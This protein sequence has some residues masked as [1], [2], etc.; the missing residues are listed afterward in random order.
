M[1]SLIPPIG[2]DYV[3]QVRTSPKTDS[4]LS[5]GSHSGIGVQAHRKGT[6]DCKYKRV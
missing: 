3:L 1:F 5:R 6:L 2:C 4:E